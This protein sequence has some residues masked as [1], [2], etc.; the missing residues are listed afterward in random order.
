M[1]NLTT[2]EVKAFVPARD[3]A[4]SKQSYQDLGFELAWSN[5]NLAYLHHGNSSF[6]PIV[7]P[8]D[9][10]G[11]DP[12]VLAEHC[13]RGRAKVLLCMPRVH[14]PTTRQLSKERRIRVVELIHKFGLSLIEDDVYGPSPDRP[15]ASLS[16][17]CPGRSYYVG[18]LSKS[19]APGLRIG[20]IAA[21]ASAIPSLSAIGQSLSWMVS[22]LMA[23]LAAEWITTGLAEKI[24]E[25]H[26]NEVFAR[27]EMVTQ[28]FDGLTFEADRYNTHV[29]LS[30]PEQWLARDF[31]VEAERAGISVVSGDH[32]SLAT[33][34]HGR[35]VRVAIGGLPSREELKR[36]LIV[37]SEI[38]RGAG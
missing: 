16:T 23:E 32:F 15:D 35:G 34:A 26:R 27:Q 29:W 4:L 19:L 6:L 2:I 8:I 5:D 22:P 12:N 18:S 37:L 7:I 1:S 33:H 3:F 17:E 24:A 20:F 38:C 11:L 36:G 9:R 10:E 21:P 25:E 13:E 30:L 14:N 28:I 31:V